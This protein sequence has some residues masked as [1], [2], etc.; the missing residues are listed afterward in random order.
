MR[1]SEVRGFLTDLLHLIDAQP[2]LEQQPFLGVLEIPPQDIL[3]LIDA[4]DEGI[5]V[6]EQLLGRF[7]DITVAGKVAVQRFHH[8]GGVLLVV[9]HQ[10]ADGKG[11]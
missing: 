9:F 11:V 8:I 3:D 4:V 5:A 1:R 2:Q 6:D 10:A 7:A